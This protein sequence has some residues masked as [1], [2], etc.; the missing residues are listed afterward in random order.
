MTRST[1]PLA[2]ATLLLLAALPVPA[3]LGQ[4]DMVKVEVGARSALEPHPAIHIQGD[5]GFEAPLS[6]VRGGQGTP[7]APYVISGWALANERGAALRIM[8]TR[9][10]VVVE[11]VHVAGHVGGPGNVAG[12]RVDARTCGLPRGVHLLNATN[13]TLRHLR[14]VGGIEGIHVRFS[15]DVRVEDVEIGTGDLSA[16]RVESGL[17][18]RSSER[19]QVVNLTVGMATVSP[20]EIVA[21]KDVTVTDSYLRSVDSPSILAGLVR[22]ALARLTVVDSSFLVSS[23]LDDVSLVDSVVRGAGDGFAYTGSVDPGPTS[24]LRICGNTFEGLGGDAVFV[25][26]LSDVTV[27][28]NRFLGNDGGVNALIGSGLHVLGNVFEGNALHG[29]LGGDGL[30]IHQNSFGLGTARGVRLSGTAVNASDNWW[31]HAT[32]PSGAPGGNGSLLRLGNAGITWAPWLESTP[33]YAPSCPQ[34][35]VGAPAAREPLAI[36]QEVT[37]EAMVRVGGVKVGREETLRT[38]PVLLP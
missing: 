9:A 3:A 34:V 5:A 32:G 38:P 15:S 27:D 23:Y 17:I 29:N 7:E 16:S 10:H 19:V 1:L 8:D 35:D 26:Q 13:V 6:G 31:G 30:E 28:G 4:P 21:V 20:L 37:V 36:Q 14:V 33:A 12:C 25:R 22:V 11:D 24:G 2:I 18:V